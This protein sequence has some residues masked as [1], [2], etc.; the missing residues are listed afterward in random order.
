MSNLNF[1]KAK[2]DCFCRGCDRLLEKN[3][4][5]LV[6][7]Y[8]FRNRGQHIYFCISCVREMFRLLNLSEGKK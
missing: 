2:R 3:L 6:S 1:R 5:D 4:D 7:T 8:S